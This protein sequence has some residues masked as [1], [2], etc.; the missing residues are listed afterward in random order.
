MSKKQRV[1]EAAVSGVGLF[2]HAKDRYFCMQ[3]IDY[4]SALLGCVD[5][6]ACRR[7]AR[8]VW[9]QHSAIAWE[10]DLAL[11]RPRPARLELFLL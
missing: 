5:G 6:M 3:K 4:L 1:S 2:L 11:V 7:G 8:S 10:P 9:M